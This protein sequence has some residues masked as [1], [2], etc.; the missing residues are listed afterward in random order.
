MK[1]TATFA[2]PNRWLPP[3]CTNLPHEPHRW[4]PHLHLP[5]NHIDGCH[6]TAL[7]VHYHRST[8]DAPALPHG[9]PPCCKTDEIIFLQFSQQRKDWTG[10][11]EVDI[12]AKRSGDMDMLRHVQISSKNIYK[13]SKLWHNFKCWIFNMLI[14]HTIKFFA[15]R[16]LWMFF[17]QR[18]RSCARQLFCVTLKPTLLFW[19]RGLL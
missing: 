10:I 13:I 11:K 14:F 2:L 5:T 19:H 15:R 4:L 8:I 1:C 16:S 12:S 7:A 3:H 17:L 9:R 6:H 18:L